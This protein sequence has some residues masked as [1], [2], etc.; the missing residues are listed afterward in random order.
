MGVPSI[1]VNDGRHLPGLTDI[2]IYQVMD[3]TTSS[4]EVLDYLRNNDPEV[5]KARQKGMIQRL[6]G[7]AS[8]MEGAM[9]STRIAELLNQIEVAPQLPV[10]YPSLKRF[11]LCFKEQSNY[12]NYLNYLKSKLFR[13]ERGRLKR[14]KFEKIPNGLTAK[15]IGDHLEKLADILGDDPKRIHCRQVAHNLVE[16]EFN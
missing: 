9:A 1:Q 10:S 12:L 13:K 15:E 3:K 6:E 5:L 2:A 14:S 11:V 16:I 8:S 7:L 4:D